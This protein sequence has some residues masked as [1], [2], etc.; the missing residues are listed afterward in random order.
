MTRQEIETILARRLAAMQRRD[1][2]A[3]AATH[4]EDS[5]Y[6]SMFIGTVQGRTA[7][8]SL[9]RDFFL[10]FP[11]AEVELENQLIDGDRAAISW[12]YRGRHLGEFCGLPATGRIFQL[13]MA[14][15]FVFQNGGIVHARS[16]YD[17]TGL[18]VQI[19]VL[20]AKPAF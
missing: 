1:P 12:S 8:A 10:A 3:I 11:D 14:L 18:L 16:I 13:H 17:L 2:E 6:T 7:I 4:A 19:G 15:F 5:V 9:Y 20:K